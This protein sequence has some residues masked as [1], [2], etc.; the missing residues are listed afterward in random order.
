M[1]RS[2]AGHSP[3]SG[4]KTCDAIESVDA[5]IRWATDAARNQ[6]EAARLAEERTAEED[7]RIA[8]EGAAERQKSLERLV[9]RLGTALV[10]A[11][12]IPSLFGDTVKLHDPDRLMDFIGMVLVMVGLAGVVLCRLTGRPNDADARGSR[13]RLSVSPASDLVAVSILAVGVG[14]LAHVG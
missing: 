5:E 13:R 4:T 2:D 10:I 14:M 11:A 9:G 3:D 8:R 1:P 6:V 12:L 7:A